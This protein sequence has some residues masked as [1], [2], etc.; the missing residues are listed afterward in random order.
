MKVYRAANSLLP[1]YAGR[2]SCWMK[3]I[4][5]AIAYLDNPGFGGDNLYEGT[6]PEGDIL[7]VTPTQPFG[8]PNIPREFLEVYTREVL[9]WV[10]FDDPEESMAY[11]YLSDDVI[12]DFINNPLQIVEGRTGRRYPYS[13]WEGE[14]LMIDW[15]KDQGY[16]A[17]QYEDDYPE[18]AVA[19]F[20]VQGSVKD[21][22]RIGGK[23]LL[24][25]HPDYIQTKEYLR[26]RGIGKGWYNES[27]RHSLAARGV[28]TR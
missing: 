13:L 17:I 7:D 20:V 1:Y 25:D 11:T 15:L 2:G 23:E 14:P 22:K 24:E 19:Y 18:R 21:I 10:P 26:G 6:L 5:D 28:R 27:Y 4:S 3:D 8:P 16:V 12:E 9:R